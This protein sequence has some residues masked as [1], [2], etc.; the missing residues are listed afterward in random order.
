MP[1]AADRKP[2]REYFRTEAMKVFAL[3]LLL[4]GGI[5]AYGVFR[6]R[7]RLGE[8]AR[9][10]AEM[11][12]ARA[13][14]LRL[15][16]LQG[17]AEY[18]MS[19]IERDLA[20]SRDGEAPDPVPPA[21]LEEL[22]EV[23]RQT[24]SPR[25]MPFPVSGPCAEVIDGFREVAGDRDLLYS[26]SGDGRW[27]QVSGDRALLRWAVREIFTNTAHHAGAWS[28]IAVLAEPVEDAVLLT[29]RDDGNGLDRTSCSRLYSPFTPRAGS[30]GPGLGL[31]VARRIVESMGGTIEARSAPGGGLLHRLRLPHPAQGPYGDTARVTVHVDDR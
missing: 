6:L 27:L 23:L 13:E 25:P 2:R 24:F 4:S 30:P 19:R 15:G 1:G 10:G 11:R 26:E 3:V 20:H 8:A 12:A 17:E 22:R 29:I 7:R 28:R 18:V 31:Y 16:R 14:R 21:R 5:I 9:A